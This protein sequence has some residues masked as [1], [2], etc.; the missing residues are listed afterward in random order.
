MTSQESYKLAVDMAIKADLRGEEKVLKYLQ[1]KKDKYEKIK[2]SEKK[3]Y[4]QENLN[5][6]YSDT[7]ILFDNKKEIKKILVGIDA[8]GPELM[9]AKNLGADLVISHHPEGGALADL[10]SVMDLQAEVLALYGLPINIAESVIKLRISEV[11]RSVS[12]SNHYRWV[13]MARALNLNYMCTH[14]SADNLGARYLFDLI[15]KQERDLEYVEDILSLLD[16]IP[17]YNESKKRK[18]GPL[19]FTGSPESRC[20]KI[21]ITE[22]TGGTS[23]SK[24]VYEKMAQY[25]IGTIVGMHMHEEHRKEAE[26]HHI[27]VVIAGHMASDSLGMNIFLDELE[28][29][30]VEVI[31]SAGLIRIKR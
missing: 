29:K 26:K 18:A 9:L 27:N 17:E 30:G 2:D 14:T 24:D 21:V 1:R 28:K 22:F 6:P 13:D 25:G 19:L 12:S 16:K 23:G 5:N 15:S 20:G 10:H 3:D 31:P 8:E 7:R 11:S 4:D